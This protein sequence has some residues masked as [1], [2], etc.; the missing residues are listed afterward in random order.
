MNAERTTKASLSA[1]GAIARAQ[2]PDR[3]YAVLFAA[4]EKREALFALIAFNYEV[5]R[6]REII[7][8]PL[9]GEM[10]L[11]WWQEVIDDI[12]TPRAPRPHPV[13]QALDAAYRGSP[14][15]LD[16][17]R[18]LTE[19]RSFDLH[20]DAMADL[21]AL[22]SYARASG[23]NLARLMAEV[24]L[25]ASNQS[26]ALLAGAGAAGTS[27][28]LT[29]IIRSLRIH[30]SRGQMFLPARELGA[31]GISPTSVLAGTVSGGLQ[32]V[33]R[34]ILERA[35][36]ELDEARKLKFGAALPAVLYCAQLPAYW[37]RMA[38]VDFD[39]FRSSIERSDFARLTTLMRA[40]L[41]KKI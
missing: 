23:G 1:C 22:V 15:S 34:E 11:A 38:R 14:F 29:G 6:L 19:A 20:N 40:A 4:A 18:Q 37:R 24:L 33:V 30:A 36:D 26:A 21:D 9:I 31:R 41:F 27:W 2:D 12:E 10:R 7:S 8:E 25:P 28:A 13:A 35:R 5:A 3:F 17:L 16:A 32:V 39:P